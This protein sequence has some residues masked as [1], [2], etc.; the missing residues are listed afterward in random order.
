M[1]SQPHPAPNAP[2]RG[3]DFAQLG[4]SIAELVI[5]HE[6]D[7]KRREE[8]TKEYVA[9]ASE[10]YPNQNFVISHNGGDI[11]GEHVHDHVELSVNNGTIGYEIFASPKGKPFK[12]VRKGDGGFINWAYAGE[13]TRVDDSTITAIVK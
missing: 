9:K 2:T 11:E 12:F 8:F 5:S 10:Q 6:K 3:G 7:D 4:I 1:N 13:F